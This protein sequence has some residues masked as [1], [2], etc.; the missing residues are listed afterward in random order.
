MTNY[1]KDDGTI[2]GRVVK[3]QHNTYLA[4]WVVP[5][6]YWSEGQDKYIGEY[7]SAKIA[8]QKMKE[9]VENKWE[10]QRKAKEEIAIRSKRKWFWF[11]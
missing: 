8:E 10:E 3:S 7:D 11:V 5:I 9:W 2:F 6:G 4:Y 1:R